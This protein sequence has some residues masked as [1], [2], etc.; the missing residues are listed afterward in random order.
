MR[1]PHAEH[2]GSWRREA[3]NCPRNRGNSNS[4]GPPRCH[5][6]RNVT[7]GDSCFLNYGC[8]FDDLAPISLGHG[9]LVAQEVV[10]ITSYHDHK[11]AD[12]NGKLASKPITGGESLSTFAQRLHRTLAAAR[13]RVRNP[14]RRG[15]RRNAT[16]WTKV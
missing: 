13:A 6:A 1:P 3:Q 12:G 8:F 14:F 7:I 15:S 10:F 16:D 2:L 4:T 11:N 9:C 5:L